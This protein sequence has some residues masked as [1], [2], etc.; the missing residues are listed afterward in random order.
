MKDKTILVLGPN[1]DM[2]IHGG[3]VT[4]MKMLSALSKIDDADYNLEFFTIGKRKFVGEGLSKREIIS[5]FFHYLLLV[6]NK[7]I[8]LVHINLSMLNNSILKNFIILLSAKIFL[9]KTIIQ[10]H[11]GDI[12]KVSWFFKI[13]LSWMVKFA[14]KI[15]VLT[16]E[17]AKIRKYLMTKNQEKVKKIPNFIDVENFKCRKQ[18][19]LQKVTFLFVGRVITEKGVFEMVKA[20]Q[21]LYQQN[22]DFQINIMGDGPDLNNFK[23]IIIKNHL[24]KYFI[25]HGFVKNESVKERIFNNSDILLLPS[26]YDEGFPYVIL[27]A[28]SNSMPVIA[29]DA[30]AISDIIEENVNGFLI[31]KQNANMLFERMKFFILQK[32]KIEFLGLNA[33]NTIKSY[34]SLNSM[35]IY[36]TEIYKSE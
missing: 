2:E 22:L 35:K 34:Y 32:E 19:H 29:T 12:K 24:E 15:L 21:K 9:K 26:Y 33:F 8:N 18:F 31:S 11:G 7:K 16:D 6:R 4:H 3:I 13:L 10:F 36:F 1:I 14:N 30:G 23:D 25:F 20:A 27:E 5:D 28:M 17:Q